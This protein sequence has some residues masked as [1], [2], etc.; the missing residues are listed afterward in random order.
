MA[1]FVQN[2]PIET[3]T[4][5]IE[6]TVSAANALRVGRHRFQLVVVDDSGN[7]SAPDVAEVLIQDTG[8]PTAHLTAPATA[9]FGS[10]FGLSGTNSVDLGGGRIVRYRWTYLGPALTPVILGGATVPGITVGGGPGPIS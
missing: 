3:D 7:E 6:V 10:S 4:P 2:T 9:P 1:T 5:T 8:R